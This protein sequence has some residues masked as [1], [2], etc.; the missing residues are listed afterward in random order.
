[1]KPIP[2]V[3]AKEPITIIANAHPGKLPPLSSGGGGG[4]GFILSTISF[5]GTLILW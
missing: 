5:R 2:A 4:G 3:A 1:M